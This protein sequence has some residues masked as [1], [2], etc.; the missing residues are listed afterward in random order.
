MDETKVE[1]DGELV[2]RTIA[3]PADT[4]SNGDI[5]GGWVLSQMDLGG[6]IIAKSNSPTGRAVTVS[7]DSMSFINSIKVGD[8]VSCYAKLIHRGRTSMKIQIEAWTYSYISQETKHVTH[9]IFTY[10]A[11]DADGKPCQLKT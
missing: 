8:L 11:I 10:V 7:I 2:M 9:G 5:F 4:N 1:I 6:G 3:M